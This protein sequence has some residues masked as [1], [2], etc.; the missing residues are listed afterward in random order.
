MTVIGW[1]PILR[2]FEQLK[3]IVFQLV[4]IDRLK[5]LSVIKIGSQRI[6]KIGLLVEQF[7]PQSIR[8]PIFEG[9]PQALSTFNAS[10][11]E[12]APTCYSC[13][14]CHYLFPNL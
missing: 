6:G 13:V 11:T 2:C 9:W 3:N 10:A 14:I 12:R 4:Q 8:P 1:P 7:Y 5:R